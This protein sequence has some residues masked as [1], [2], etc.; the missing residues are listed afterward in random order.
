MH[1]HIAIHAHRS[2]QSW[3]TMADVNVDK[4]N[5]M[6]MQCASLK[7]DWTLFTKRMKFQCV[8][9]FGSTSANVAH[10]YTSY[11]WH[12]LQTHF[13]AY[14]LCANKR[15]KY[16]Y[17]NLFKSKHERDQRRE[18]KRAREK[19]KQCE[20]KTG[21][22]KNRRWTTIRWNTLTDVLHKR[23]QQTKSRQTKYACF[24]VIKMKSLLLNG[25]KIVCFL[26]VDVE[27]VFFFIHSLINYL[28]L[29]YTCKAAWQGDFDLILNRIYL[30]CGNKHIM[31]VSLSST[32][33]KN[34]RTF[35]FA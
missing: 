15:Q 28:Q 32:S 1:K 25:R 13:Y 8:R 35:S 26:K 18:S 5:S 19:K 4:W 7:C 21:Q 10:L 30:F 24:G 34:G 29:A 14:I 16:V 3:D 2:V 17:N 31:Y 27:I 33:L 6:C 12:N 22:P 20:M 11:N 23:K 9:F